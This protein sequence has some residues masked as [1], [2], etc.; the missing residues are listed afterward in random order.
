MAA[1]GLREFLLVHGSGEL[2]PNLALALR[3][4]SHCDLLP[5]H[6]ANVLSI[7]RHPTLLLTVRAMHELEQED[8]LRRALG[9]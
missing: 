4:L 9:R 3:N 5:A 8:I 6:G 1:L 7:L 2:D